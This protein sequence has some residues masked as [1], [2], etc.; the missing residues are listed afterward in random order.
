MRTVVLRDSYDAL[1]KRIKELDKEIKLNSKEIGRAAELG[2]LSENAEFD[3]AKEKQTELFTTLNNLETYVSGRIIESDEINTKVV[4]FGTT[5]KIFDYTDNRVDTYTLAGPV[6]FELEIYPSIMTF[7]SPLGQAL[8]GKKKGT[9]V[10]IDLPRGLSKFLILDI[11]SVSGVEEA[12]PE[13][14]IFG[15]VGHDIITTDKKEQGTYPGGSAY[16]T[17]VGASLFTNRIA[18]VACVDKADKDLTEAVSKLSTFDKAIKTVSK[19]KIS[20][21]NLPKDYYGAKY[22]HIAAAPP[23]Q[24]LEWVTAIKANADIDCKV[25]LDIDEQYIKEHEKTLQKLLDLCDILF[26]TEAEHKLLKGLETEEKTIILKKGR[27]TAEFW[28]EGEMEQEAEALELAVVD[29]TGFGGV[30]AGAFVG[31]LTLGH[32]EETAI[33]LAM[34]IAC[35]AQEDFGVDHLIHPKHD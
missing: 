2:D 20:F 9:L 1:L 13:L 17:A 24:Q 22:F 35:K 32:L 16:H 8:N 11:K 7:T 10:D 34:K 12:V 5:V 23:D 14:V 31:M 21:E 18:L 29:P 4:S 19:A 27:Q 26:V 15:P 28:I 33:D 3:A 30:M 6:E 25:S